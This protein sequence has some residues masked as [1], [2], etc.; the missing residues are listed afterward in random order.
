MSACLSSG[1]ALRATNLSITGT[2][3]R[4]LPP[5]DHLANASLIADFDGDTDP[6]RLITEH[7]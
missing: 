4:Q 2:R 1:S 7:R 6:T 3:E 5:L